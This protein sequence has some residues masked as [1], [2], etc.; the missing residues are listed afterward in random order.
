MRA[1]ISKQSRGLSEDASITNQFF[2]FFFG[3]V[4]APKGKKINTTSPLWC[5]LLLM[6]VP[7]HV[8]SF[9]IV[10]FEE[11]ARSAALISLRERLTA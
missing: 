7:S 11:V 1:H 6:S 4:V 8:I 9:H 3:T 2:F 10:A 5:F